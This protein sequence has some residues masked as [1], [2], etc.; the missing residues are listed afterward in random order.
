MVNFL[1]V[2]QPSGYNTIIGR[3][4]L[5][6]LRAVIS[7]NHL[8]M[9]FPVGDLVGE[10]RSD[11]AESRQY[12]A[13]STKVAKKHKLINTIFH[14]EDIKVPPTPNN[15][16]HK[17]G[18]LVRWEKEKEKRGHPFEELECIKLDD[19]HPEHTVQIG[20]QLSGSLW[21]QLIS[22]LKEHRDVF[23]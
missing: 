15:I 18:E 22:F 6:A 1:L 17:L 21:N 10:V 19:Q 7:I 5:N 4:T 8:A 11:Q 16:S 14:L 23:A 12:Y 20:S 2:D 3:P 9:K 13:M